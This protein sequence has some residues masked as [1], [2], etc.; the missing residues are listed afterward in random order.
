[1]IE[2]SL[3][4]TDDQQMIRDA[5]RGF[6]SNVVEPLADQR[7]ENIEFPADEI[8]AAAEIGLLGMTIPEE[9]DG[10]PLDAVSIALAYEEI[11]SASASVSVILSVHNTLVAQAIAHHAT[12]A[13]RQCYLPAMAAGTRLGSYALT[14]PDA[15]SD[16]AA[17]RTRAE[18]VDGGFAISGEK[19]FI[20]TAG[21][22]GIIVVFAVTD[23][24]AR[25]SRR[26]SAFAVDPAD[27]GVTIGPPERKMGILASEICGISFNRC[28]VDDS[29]LLGSVGGGFAIAMGLLSAGRIGIAAQA[30]GIAASA[31]TKSRDYA[32]SRKQFGQSISSF[33]A[34]QWKLADMATEL[35]AARLLIWNAARLKDAGRAYSAEASKA[36][37]FASELAVRAANDAV[38]IH[39]GYGYLKDYGVERLYRD[40]KI[41]EIYEGTSEIQ[42]LV[43]ARSILEQQIAGR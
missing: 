40:A 17:I 31:L 15:G 27:D 34:I 29:R 7:D 30:A 42:R 9:F 14:E 23:S 28:F 10:F 37:L 13:I 20:S 1:M 4:L 32:T 26:I 19:V 2:T 25:T 6:A 38:Q 21:H 43:I 39:G 35:E 16:A 24:D 8:A 18:R 12:D 41:T 3:P 11:A 22:A 36:K 5:T 33:Q